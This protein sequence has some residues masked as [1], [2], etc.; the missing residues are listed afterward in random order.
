MK[1][2][3]KFLILSLLFSFVS[4]GLFLDKGKGALEGF[5]DAEVVEPVAVLKAV[6]EPVLE[7]ILPVVEVILPVVESVV[8]KDDDK[9]T[10][11]EIVESKETSKSEEKVESKD[12]KEVKET[13]IKGLEVELQPNN[14]DDD[15]KYVNDALY[16]IK[17]IKEKRSDIMDETLAISGDIEFVKKIISQKY[18][19]E[20]KANERVQL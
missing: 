13:D 4:C 17:T 16:W 18:Q 8:E 19:Q 20:G 1:F 3:N 7:A 14:Y 9:K 6:V 2:K 15:V 10:V 11:E 5:R 12:N